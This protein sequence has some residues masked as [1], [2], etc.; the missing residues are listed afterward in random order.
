MPSVCFPGN[1]TD[2][3]WVYDWTAPIPMPQSQVS[4]NAMVSQ[5]PVHEESL[6]HI[7]GAVPRVG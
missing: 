4:M 2:Y 7:A 5:K 1:P 3:T 6:N